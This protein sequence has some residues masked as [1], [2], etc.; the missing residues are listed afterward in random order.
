MLRMNMYIK[1]DVIKIMKIRGSTICQCNYKKI[2]TCMH[3]HTHTHTHIHMNTPIQFTK[4]TYVCICG[5]VVCV[6]L[7]TCICS[8]SPNFHHFNDVI[9]NVPIHSQHFLHQLLLVCPLL[10]APFFFCCLS[11]CS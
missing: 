6:C 10:Y 1:N 5:Y 3:A 8:Y 11:S 4:C 7:H 2:Q 9:F